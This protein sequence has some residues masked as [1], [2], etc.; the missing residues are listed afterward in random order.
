MGGGGD[1]GVRG[2]DG[3]HPPSHTLPVVATARSHTDSHQAP[4]H[5]SLMARLLRTLEGGTRVFR[6]THNS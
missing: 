2:Q 4:V 3:G 6:I 1:S 5:L